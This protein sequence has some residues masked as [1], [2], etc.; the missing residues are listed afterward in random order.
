MC[1]PVLTYRNAGMI[2]SETLIGA[3]LYLMAHVDMS[4]MV[5]STAV[6]SKPGV[7]LDHDPGTL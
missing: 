5:V 2:L 3:G 7:F 4:F 6:V 1:L